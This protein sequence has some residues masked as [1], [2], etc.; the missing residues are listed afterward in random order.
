MTAAI[1]EAANAKIN[2]FLHV[3][4]RRPDGYH[5]LQ[6]LVVFADVGDTVTA[7][8]SGMLSLSL[9]GPFGDLLEVSEDNLVLRAA[10]TLQDRAFARRGDRPGAALLLTKRLP[11]ASGIGGGSADAAATLRA[12]NRLWGLAL[13]DDEMQ[14][15]AL[16]LG[17]DVPVCLGSRACVMSG[18][19]ETLTDIPT[20]PPVWVV[21]ANP[22]RGLETRGVFS[23]R[24]PKAV[25]LL[26]TLPEKF[27]SAAAL[28]DWLATETRNDLSVA[29]R[30]ILPEISNIE[31]ALRALPGALY[32]GMS[33]SG[34]TCFALFTERSEA[35][36]G[37]RTLRVNAPDW[38]VEA[39][40]IRNHDEE[41][42]HPRRVN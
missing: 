28:A 12:L 18:I 15:L 17:A 41:R 38:W 14:A 10:L 27:S 37:A 1:R 35:L 21:M 24:D 6:S 32:T 11:V 40:A 23:V 19:G 16:S 39:G 33:G 5:T 31:N 8:P 42:P 13:P 34:A 3:T 29:A 9:D 22:L 4:G 30:S 7:E 25:S 36:K 20:L 26:V 2:L